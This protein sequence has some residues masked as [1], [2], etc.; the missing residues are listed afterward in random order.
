[1]REAT[2]T[3]KG[4]GTKKGRRKGKRKVGG[5]AGDLSREVSTGLEGSVETLSVAEEEDVE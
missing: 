4:T 1:V 5:R 3:V 2:L